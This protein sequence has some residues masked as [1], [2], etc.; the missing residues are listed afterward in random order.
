MVFNYVY[1]LK[2]GNRIPLNADVLARLF[3][4]VGQTDLTNRHD[5]EDL[6][7]RHLHRKNHRQRLQSPLFLQ[8]QVLLQA[9]RF[10]DRVG[11]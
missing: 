1:F 10:A 3:V 2:I 8:G 11:R 5:Y 4:C 6:F 7:R 9:S